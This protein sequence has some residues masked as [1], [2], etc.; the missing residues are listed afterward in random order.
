MRAL[1]A[2]GQIG[3]PALGIRLP[4]DQRV[5]DRRAHSPTMSLIDLG[6]LDVGVLERL[7]DA[8][9]MPSDL[10][11]QLLPRSGQVAELLY[12]RGA[13]RSCRGSSR[14]PANRASHVASFTSLLRPGTFR[15]C[16]ALASVE[17]ESGP[18]A[19][20]RPASSTPPVASIATWVHPCARQPVRQFQQA[21]ASSST[22]C[23]VRSVTVWPTTRRAQATTCRAW[24]SNPA[25]R[26]YRTSITRLLRARPGV[27]SA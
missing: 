10:A 20:A 17:L 21:R 8:L 6:Q 24:T 23:D 4:G 11:H 26:G 3:Q 2:A 1:S 12:R 27:E 13:G 16:W 5:Q 25:H 7:L 22:P 18:R 19:H 14:A 15:M 9:R